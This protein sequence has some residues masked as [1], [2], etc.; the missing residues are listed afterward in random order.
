[1][2]S[3]RKQQLQHRG[4]GGHG[5][6]PWP[7]SR[8]IHCAWGRGGS[9]PAPGKPSD[10]SCNT[11]GGFISRLPGQLITAP[12]LLGHRLGRSATT[13]TWDTRGDT[14]SPR[15][16]PPP[17]PRPRAGVL[18]DGAGFSVVIGQGRDD[19]QERVQSTWACCHR[20]SRCLGHRSAA[21]HRRS[22]PP[23][24]VL[25]AGREG[26]ALSLWI[27]IAAP[28]DKAIKQH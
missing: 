26:G 13:T 1:M 12:R 8:H 19:L 23:G 28:G 22:G 6:P 4:A 16:P 20:G 2:G 9:S 7:D 10:A 21:G 27:L 15:P 18:Q 3:K 5:D 17:A 14:R 24:Q 25:R 11:W